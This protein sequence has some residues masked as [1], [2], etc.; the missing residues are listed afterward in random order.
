MKEMRMKLFEKTPVAKLDKTDKKIL[1]V[2]YKNSRALIKEIS[3]KTGIQR[4]VVK[5]RID[6]MKKQG[7]IRYF[8][9]V[10]N[11]A[12]MGHPIYTW[13][14]IV[15]QSFDPV[16]QKKFQ[17]YLL[18]HKNI[19]YMAKVSGKYHFVIAICA[20]DLEHFE[21][22]FE[23]ILE[24]FSH[25]IKEYNSSSLIEEYKYDYMVDLID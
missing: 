20:K 11:P 6:K 18:Y 17:N 16:E 15:F 2:L 12:K 4:D 19:A 13:I 14:N 23:G 7:V 21:Q 10:L 22:I 3:R 5:Y 9:T 24:K 25:L 8:T 1:G